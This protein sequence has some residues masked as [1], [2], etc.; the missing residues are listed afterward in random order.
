LFDGLNAVQSQSYG[1]EARGGASKA[2]VIIS[3]EEIDFPKVT[4]CDVLLSLTKLSCDKYISGLRAGGILIID[5]SIEKPERDDIITY[6]LPIL[7]T[8][9]TTLNKPMVA[10]IIALGIINQI[11]KIVSKESLEKA[12]LS[13]VPKGTEELNIK[14]L[15]EGFILA[16]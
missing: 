11:T 8:A 5:E 15:K 9:V 7:K 14:A 1:P 12:V 6:S 3:E 4:D 13:R 2:E 16:R 10:N